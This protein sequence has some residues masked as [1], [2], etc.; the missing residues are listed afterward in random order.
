M[1]KPMKIVVG[2]DHAGFAMRIL[3]RAED[4]EIAEADGGEVE[5][6]RKG[7]G[8]YTV[9]VRGKAAHAGVDPLKPL[10]HRVGILEVQPDATHVGLVEDVRRNDLEG[11]RISDT[12]GR[13]HRLVHGAGQDVL[14]KAID[15][16]PERE[17]QLIA[18]YYFE[19]LTLREISRIFGLGE[20]RVG[21]V[22]GLGHARWV[23]LA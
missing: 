22:K 14:G 6:A 20:P 11:D 10:C 16:L 21:G 13:G 8:T 12:R 3:A 4:I 15:M 1:G 2:S 18:F 23:A 9:T 7:V 5:S 19:D 17:Q